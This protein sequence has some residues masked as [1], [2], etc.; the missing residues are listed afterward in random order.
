MNLLFADFL[1]VVLFL[2]ILFAMSL[3]LS[4]YLERVFAR[5]KTSADKVLG[6]IEY[7]IL[8]FL[9][10]HSD[11]EQTWKQYC[12]DVLMFSFLALLGCFIFLKFAHFFPSGNGSITA[13]SALTAL[14][15]SVSYLTNTNWQAFIPEIQMS[16]WGQLGPLTLLNFC[17]SAIG[18]SV[19]V[20]FSRGIS[21]QE[22]TTVGYFWVDLFRAL[23][24][25]LMPL[26]FLS[27]LVLN[28]AGVVQGVQGNL[29]YTGVDG[30]E[31]RFQLGLVASQSSIKLLGS[32]GGGYFSAGSAHPFENP[33]GFTNAFQ[34]LLILLLPSSLILMFGRLVQNAKHSFSLWLSVASVFAAG[35]LIC[36]ISEQGTPPIE[37]TQ[38]TSQ[39]GNI[40]GKELRFGVFG[41]C[42]FSVSSAATSCGAMNSSISSFMPLGTIVLLTKMLVGEVIFGGIG[43]GLYGIILFVILTCFLAGLMVGR[44]PEYLGKKIDPFD[45]TI[46]SVSVIVSST[47]I[48]VGTA[49]A[50]GT[51]LGKSA[52]SSSG[53]NGFINAFYAI[54]STTQNNGSAMHGVEITSHLYLLMT[55][56]TMLLGRYS[57]II[58]VL[59][60]AGSMAAKKKRAPSE[61][62]FPTHGILFS[63]LF[64][65]VVFIVGALIYFPTLTLG[66]IL[67]FLQFQ[68]LKNSGG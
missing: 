22:C 35:V 25:V 48:L 29:N 5:P 38:I 68:A 9:K 10:V 23:I 19:A 55:I 63:L 28:S 8:R 67:K 59:A 62:S 56:F 44:T 1:R 2:S 43:S 15:V 26:S 42:L 61:T 40:E 34:S 37:T 54:T 50:L 20:A 53:V 41:T 39:L 11:A 58:L 13:M 12:S 6:S 30:F 24:F 14:N 45:I 16:I 18:I 4:I 32:N 27:A 64:L 51:N 46:A 17:S 52:L 21:R 65:L 60:I 47:V 33:T 7:Y 31:Q 57:G 3:P 49:L 36:L 66:P